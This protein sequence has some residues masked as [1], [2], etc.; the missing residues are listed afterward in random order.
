[1]DSWRCLALIRGRNCPARQAYKQLLPA[2]VPYRVPTYVHPSLPRGSEFPYN[3]S[4]EG[5]TMQGGVIN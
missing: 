1:M 3:R 5:W 4:T 2:S